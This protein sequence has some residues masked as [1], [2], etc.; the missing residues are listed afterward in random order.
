MRDRR[1]HQLHRVVRRSSRAGSGPPPAGV[2]R[3]PQPDRPRLVELAPV[4]LASV[5]AVLSLWF[6]DRQVSNQLRIA[7]DEPSATKEGQITGRYTA[8]VGRLGEDAVDVRQ[9]GI[10]ALQ[11]IMEDRPRDHPT[12]ADVLAAYI[13]THAGTPPKGG[14]QVPPDV[15]AALDVISGRNPAH[16]GSFVP[17]LRS[18]HLPG[19]ELGRDPTSP[20]AADH[21]RAQLRRATLRDAGLRGAHPSGAD[22]R[23]ARLARA[24]LADAD[25]READLREATPARANLRGAELSDAGLRMADLRFADLR[26]ADLWGTDLCGADLYRANLAG[27]ELSESDLDGADLRGADLTD[28]AVATSQV[29]ATRIDARTKLPPDIADD[30]DVRARIAQAEAEDDGF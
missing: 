17:G 20:V 10:H 6:S 28:A 3:R 15:L 13:R 19:V 7:R 25:L 24:D 1:T 14:K 30:P 26:D 2:R 16:D 12:I 29:L 18:T 5:V 9:G 23:G 22:L 8:A 27:L 21:R 4:L 11:R